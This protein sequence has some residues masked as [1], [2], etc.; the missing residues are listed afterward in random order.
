MPAE[1]NTNNSSS[2][3]KWF[4]K[5]G[6]LVTP[7]LPFWKQQQPQETSHTKGDGYV[8]FGD[9]SVNVANN[10]ATP[11]QTSE[12]IFPPPPGFSDNPKTTEEFFGFGDKHDN[13]QP[14]TSLNNIY[15]EKLNLR[16]KMGMSVQTHYYDNSSDITF[17]FDPEE[18]KEFKDNTITTTFHDEFDIAPAAGTILTIE[19]GSTAQKLGLQEGDVI[20]CVTINGTDLSIA[21]SESYEE[22][23]E[24]V[25]ALRDAARC[26]T[27]S[28]V[29]IHYNRFADEHAEAPESK[30]TQ[31]FS[32]GGGISMSRL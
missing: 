9:D 11:K 29:Q 2:L 17:G 7:V 5:V 4:Q 14:S 3:R 27:P 30:T 25:E 26:Q 31:Q 20:T 32:L 13:A 1:I 16:G 12:T 15:T 8:Q 28:K 24:L 18:I 23:E 22:A 19:E 21:D 6:A 10:P